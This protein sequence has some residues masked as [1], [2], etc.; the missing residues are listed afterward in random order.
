MMITPTRIAVV[1]A[2]ALPLG[3]SLRSATPA[4]STGPGPAETG[5]TTSLAPLAAPTKPVVSAVPS[6]SDSDYTLLSQKKSVVPDLSHRLTVTAVPPS[7]L[8]QALTNIGRLARQARIVPAFKDGRAI[9]FKVFSIRPHSLYARIGLKN[10]DI[11]TRVNGYSV[12]TPERAAAAYSLIEDVEVL[13]VEVLR[14]HKLRLLRYDMVPNGVSRSSSNFSP[15]VQTAADSTSTF[16]VDVD[17]AS[18]SLMRRSLKKNALPSPWTVRAEEMVNYFRY[19]Y[20]APNPDSAD[21][22]AVH[23]AGARSAVDVHKTLLRIGIQARNEPIG[24]I[25]AVNLVFLVDTSGSMRAND[26]LPLAKASMAIAATRL[27][28]SDRVAIIAYDD[29]PNVVLP[30]TRVAEQLRITN[31]IDSLEASGPTN[32]SRGMQAALSQANAM[33]DSSPA[34]SPS[35]TRVLLLSDGVANVQIVEP[36]AILKRVSRYIDR[37]VSVSAVGFGFASYR[38]GMMKQLAAHGNGHYV[39]IDSI[40]HAVRVFGRDFKSMIYDV[41]KDVK[42]RVE[43][44]ERCVRSHRLI[45]YENKGLP[46]GA[47]R[48]HG[49]NFGGEMGAGQQVTALYEISLKKRCGESLGRLRVAAQTPAGGPMVD[50]DKTIPRT[51]V[52]VPFASAAESVRFAAAVAGAAELLGK[53]PYASDWTFTQAAA[54]AAKAN[55]ANDSEREEFYRLMQ[56][57]DGV[58]RAA[59]KSAKYKIGPVV[60]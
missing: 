58:V 12:L 57:A 22:L 27:R 43:F 55:T 11:V 35:Q 45:G 5:P 37:G 17:T 59:A 48:M 50:V 40:E 60:R 33:I 7:D 8:S 4:K 28:P 38:D 13:F 18:Y 54:I 56:A 29:K 15:P 36:E 39:H 49:P 25:P 10:G 2:I 3:W 20:S 46:S 41:A 1:T 44:N 16:A 30:P 31:A 24:G 47:F 53:S 19:D 34:D 42:V 9:G 52:D 21:L 23:I 32:I 26:R 6:S 14:K 51:D